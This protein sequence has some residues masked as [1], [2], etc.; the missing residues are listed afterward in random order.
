[1]KNLRAGEPEEYAEVQ[2]FSNAHIKPTGEVVDYDRL[3]TPS[4]VGVIVIA[5]VVVHRT[6]R[7]A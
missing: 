2:T 1:M 4:S 3:T 7:R 6:I 5:G